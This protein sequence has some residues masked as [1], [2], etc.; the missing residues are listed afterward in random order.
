MKF[1]VVNKVSTFLVIT[2]VSSGLKKL[3]IL[4]FS[5]YKYLHVKIA[6]LVNVKSC[7]TVVPIVAVYANWLAHSRQHFFSLLKTDFLKI[8]PNNTTH[9]ANVKSTS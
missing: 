4:I 6:S 1:G 9:A 3:H 7:V 2:Q 5:K 8:T